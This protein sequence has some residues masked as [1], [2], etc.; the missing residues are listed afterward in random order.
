TGGL[1][2]RVPFG[3]IP[4]RGS[5][6]QLRDHG[7]GELVEC[8]VTAAGDGVIVQKPCNVAGSRL[9]LHR[10]TG[11]HCLVQAPFLGSGYMA[12][13]ITPFSSISATR[14]RSCTPTLQ[15]TRS[16]K[17]V[18]GSKTSIRKGP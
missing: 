15:R 10:L 2:N 14:L 18:Q 9:C 8:M 6:W 12:A 1:R 5:G 17:E 16:R 4:A 11:D 7:A 13:A 3:K